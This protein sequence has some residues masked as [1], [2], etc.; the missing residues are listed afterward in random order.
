MACRI[1]GCRT[2][3]SLA[4]PPPLQVATILGL[5]VRLLFAKEAR[6]ARSGC[7]RPLV[8]EIGAAMGALDGNRVA[9]VDVM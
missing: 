1:A 7:N 6:T 8:A 3:P 2:G 4:R 9:T 5:V